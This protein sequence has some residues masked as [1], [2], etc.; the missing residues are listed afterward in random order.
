MPPP[1]NWWWKRACN[2][3]LVVAADA[4][5]LPAL[6]LAQTIFI[7]AKLACWSYSVGATPQYREPHMRQA[8]AVD[9]MR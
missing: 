8:I 9:P 4:P 3:I 2:T 6:P 7:D 5:G 1:T